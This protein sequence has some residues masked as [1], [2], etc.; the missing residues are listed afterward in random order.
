MNFSDRQQFDGK[1]VR[2][3]R[4]AEPRCHYWV[5]IAV[6]VIGAGA[7][8]YGAE[9]QSK[10]SAATNEANKSAVQQANDQSWTDYLLE[11]GVS[12][13]SVVPAGSLPTAATGATPVNTKLPLWATVNVPTRMSGAGGSSSLAQALTGTPATPAA[14]SAPTATVPTAPGGYKPPARS[15]NPMPAGSG[16]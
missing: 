12:T 13:G 2:I 7:S 1:R 15:A 16:Y 4:G 9:S 6:A 3:R 11:R 8:V 14:A 5:D 10:S